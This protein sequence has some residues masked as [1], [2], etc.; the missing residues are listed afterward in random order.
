MPVGHWL[1]PHGPRRA[2][3][4]RIAGWP[5][6]CCWRWSRVDSLAGL[7]SVWAG[8][9]LAMAAVLYEPAFAVVATWFVRYRAPGAQRPDLAPA[10]PARSSCRWRAW[11]LDRQGWRSAIVTLAA[12]LAVTTVPLHALLLRRRSPQSIG[13]EPDGDARDR[14][15]AGNGLPSAN[16]AGAIREALGG[17]AV[18]DPHLRV[19]AGSLA[20]SRPRSI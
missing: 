6:S 17:R 19:R 12:I 18:L 11:L 4:G 7:Y 9:G 8:L 14:L 10:W 15:V 2:D 20:P 1:D 13:L 16:P 3:D 5:S